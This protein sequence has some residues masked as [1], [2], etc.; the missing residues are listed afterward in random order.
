M[1]KPRIEEIIVV[2]GKYDAA[3]LADLVDALI[4]TTD[5]FSVF[6]SEETRALIRELGAKRGIIVLTDS[7]A[8]GFRIRAYVNKLAQ[9]LCVKNAYVPAIEGK[10][11]R[12]PRPSKEG[13]LGVEGVDGALLL[14][15]LQ[16]VGAH[17]AAPRAGRAITYA[18]LYEAGLSG[19][20]NS[21]QRRRAWLRTIGLPPRL[22]KS[23]LREVLNSLYTYEEFVQMARAVEENELSA[24]P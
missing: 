10:E 2:E 8:A 16:T 4:V 3:R 9:G 6:K 17:T 20:Q 13:L 5:G 1:T 21:A 12:K 11:R 18:D 24:Q 23:A 7:D 15:A 22:S 14:Q 19:G